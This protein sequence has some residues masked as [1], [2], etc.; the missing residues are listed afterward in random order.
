MPGLVEGKVALVT[1]G[2]SGIGRAAARAFAREG[3]RVMVADVAVQGG[4][5][6]VHLIQ[7]AGGE[8]TFMQVDV[9][10]AADITALIAHTMAIYGRLDCAHNNAG[11]EGAIGPTADCT[12][13]NWERVISVNLT[14]VWLCMKYEIAQM[15]Q[16]DR[17]AIVNTASAAGL[18]GARGIP[19]Y[20][21][22]KHGD[23]EAALG[24]AD[25]IFEHTFRTPHQHQAYI[26]PHASVVSL[27]TQGRVQV[28]INSKMS[29]QVRQQRRADGWQP[30][31]SGSDDL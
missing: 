4:Q 23:I 30:A 26:E 27:D 12:E 11:I 20:V 7:D 13:D 25:H 6:T 2:S 8:A 28:W 9:T 24:A 21:A 10:R 15:L 22:S 16:Q 14:G 17:G 1:G 5:E 3:A 19:A 31:P 29:F 18:V